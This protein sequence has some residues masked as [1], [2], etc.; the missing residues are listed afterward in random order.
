MQIKFRCMFTDKHE[1]TGIGND[2]PVGADLAHGVDIFRQLV[3]IL[4][5]REQVQRQVNANAMFMGEVDPFDHI[6]KR[7]LAFDPK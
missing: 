1:N 5:V 6:I 2:Q 3:D 4:V 7:H